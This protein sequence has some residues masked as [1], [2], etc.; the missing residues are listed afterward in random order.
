MAIP[1]DPNTSVRVA[2]KLA[3]YKDLEIENMK[4]CGLKTITVPFVI[5]TLGVI[6]NGTEKHTDKIP[7]KTNITEFQKIPLQG[8]SHIFRKVL[9]IK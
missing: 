1:S 5:G 4:M 6:K 2:E 7:G 9:S 8:S 3:K